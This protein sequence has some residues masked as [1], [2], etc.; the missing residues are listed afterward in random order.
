[1]VQTTPG[2]LAIHC[3]DP[4]LLPLGKQSSNLPE[5]GQKLHRVMSGEKGGSQT[6]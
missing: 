3:R 1:M 5:D 6:K 2:L 4:G